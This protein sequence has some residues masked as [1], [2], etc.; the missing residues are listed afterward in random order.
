MERPRPATIAWGVLGAGVIAY[1]I[2]CPEGETLSEGVDRALECEK[3][4]LALGAIAIT[5][6][7]LANIIPQQIDPFHRVTQLKGIRKNQ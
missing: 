7:H 6:A 1:D 2:L 5:A 4:K 3:R